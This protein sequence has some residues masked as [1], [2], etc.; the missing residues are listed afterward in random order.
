[1]M[2]YL[3]FFSS[4]RRHT[5]LQGDWSSDVCSSDLPLAGRPP[6]ARCPDR[7]DHPELAPPRS[8]RPHGDADY[9]DAPESRLSAGGTGRHLGPRGAQPQPSKMARTTGLESPNTAAPT[10]GPA[11]A[12]SDSPGLS[13]AGA[14][15]PHGR[16]GRTLR[17]VCM[18][19]P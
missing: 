1:M 6:P 12:V 3:F 18:G 16:G 19:V 2:K 8:D 9:R 15:A 7:P 5:R 10:D 13:A 17:P 14:L 11:T 4:R